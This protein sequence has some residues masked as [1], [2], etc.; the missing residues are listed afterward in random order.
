[1]PRQAESSVVDG[2]I[3][4]AGVKIIRFFPATW[5]A[6]QKISAFVAVGGFI[7]IV[8]SILALWRTLP[9]ENCTIDTLSVNLY[10]FAG[11]FGIATVTFGIWMVLRR[12]GF[13]LF[14]WLSA[15]FGGIG[16]GIWPAMEYV[17]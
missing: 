17:C 4:Y 14:R 12:I 3:I 15:L 5:S 9:L 6:E 1:M 13:P 7:S 8:F 2:G 11:V 16:V 10:L